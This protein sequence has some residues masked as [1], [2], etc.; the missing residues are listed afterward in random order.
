MPPRQGCALGATEVQSS[1]S[2]DLVY[3]RVN[4]YD[5]PFRTLRPIRRADKEPDNLGQGSPLPGARDPAAQAVTG[6]A[7]TPARRRLRGPPPT[8]QG[9]FPVGSHRMLLA[10]T[11]ARPSRS[12]LHGGR[13]RHE[14]ARA[15]ITPALSA[16]AHRAS[17]KDCISTTM[18]LPPS[19]APARLTVRWRLIP[20]WR[21][22]ARRGERDRPRANPHRG[23]RHRPGLRGHRSHRPGEDSRTSRADRSARRQS[24]PPQGA[25]RVLNDQERRRHTVTAFICVPRHLAL[26]HEEMYRVGRASG[27]RRRASTAITLSSQWIGRSLS[28]YAA[29]L[30]VECPFVQG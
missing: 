27:G 14:I 3:T 17:P 15:I 16:T 28:G 7:R 6:T 9:Q 25:Q 30:V 29:A 12:P 20:H 22:H 2:L 11:N 19:A 1:R 26:G 5:S 24:P 18:G 8:R 4:E 23:Y 21:N 10:G 13:D